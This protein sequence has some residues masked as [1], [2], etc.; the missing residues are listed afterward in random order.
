LYFMPRICRKKWLCI[1][2]KHFYRVMRMEL[3]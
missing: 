2:Y 1:A 3:M